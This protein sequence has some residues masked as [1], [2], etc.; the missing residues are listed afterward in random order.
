MSRFAL[1]KPGTEINPGE[2][3]IIEGKPFRS[4][5]EW[6]PRGGE[7]VTILGESGRLF[8]AR[9]LELSE[10]KAKLL[11]FEEIGRFD[12]ASPEIILLQALPERE[13]LELIIQKATELGVDTV[14]PFKSEKSIS[15]E[16]RE[17]GQKKSHKW[18]EIA[19]KAAKQSRRE[20]IPQI[21]PY[22]LFKDALKATE[23]A[24]LKILLW[25][26]A[27]IPLLKDILNDAKGQAIKKIVIISGPEGGFTDI[28]VKEASLHGC[29]PV[30][31]GRRIL[32]TETAAMI[33]IGL[34]RYEVGG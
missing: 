32:R 13:R 5:L 7:A 15:L 10:T 1:I 27:G 28:E 20:T 33:A 3:I 30:S 22:A 24:E 23:G 12:E 34:V 6:H 16:E 8:R 26:K 11:P 9:V 19:L 18:Q 25:E 2:N 4:L 17:K 29:I 21:P 14:I 31:L